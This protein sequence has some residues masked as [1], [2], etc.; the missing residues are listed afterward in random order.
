M[1]RYA[2][3]NLSIIGIAWLHQSHLDWQRRRWSFCPFWHWLQH[4]DSLFQVGAKPPEVLW[5]THQHRGP[6]ISE[7]ALWVSPISKVILYVVLTGISR[8]NSSTPSHHSGFTLVHPMSRCQLASYSS[9]RYLS[10]F[11]TMPMSKGCIEWL[12]RISMLKYSSRRKATSLT[13][14][15]SLAISG[16]AFKRR[17]RRIRCCCKISTWK[18][19]KDPW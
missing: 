3:Y 4:P 14:R 15:M 12:R 16:Q 8:R 17:M 19:S 9:W 11:T 5:I 18:S 13:L 7:S 6:D 10:G 1:K 2:C